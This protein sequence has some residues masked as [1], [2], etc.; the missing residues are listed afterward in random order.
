MGAEGCRRGCPTGDI[1]REA[2]HAIFWI[3]RA[4][5]KVDDKERVGGKRG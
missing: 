5:W 2:S 1:T 4:A 3:W